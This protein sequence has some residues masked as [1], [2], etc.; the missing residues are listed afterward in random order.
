[1]TA[2]RLLSGIWRNSH[3]ASLVR[4]SVRNILWFV[5]RGMFLS[6]GDRDAPIAILSIAPHAST[7][8]LSRKTYRDSSSSVNPRSFTRFFGIGKNRSFN[9]EV[10]DASASFIP[11]VA[12]RTRTS[13]ISGLRAWRSWIQ[14]SLAETYESGRG[15]TWRTCNAFR[16]PLISPCAR[17]TR[18]VRA[19]D[20]ALSPSHSHIVL[21]LRTIWTSLGRLNRIIR[22]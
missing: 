17:P 9:T 5:R 15:T 11:F 4:H 8:R 7:S 16:Q 21:S 3:H 6:T 12:F 14:S 13:V 1:M 2:I 19:L 18:V 10:W 20:S 22:A